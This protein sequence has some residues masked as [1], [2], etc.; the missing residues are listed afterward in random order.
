M[1][2]TKQKWQQ[3]WLK[4][5]KIVIGIQCDFFSEQHSDF[6]CIEE[7]ILAK[8]SKI[9]GGFKVP[10]STELIKKIVLMEVLQRL[11]GGPF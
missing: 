3:L 9:G 8:H 1:N 7:D 2:L 6:V 11:L 4:R 5:G 10:Q